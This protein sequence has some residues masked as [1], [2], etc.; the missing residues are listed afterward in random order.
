M[1]NFVN[2]EIVSAGPALH[3]MGYANVEDSTRKRVQSRVDTRPEDEILHP[4]LKARQ[5]ANA[6]DLYRN[7]PAAV[8]AVGL[9]V[10]A[11]CN[12]RFHSRTGIKS[13]DDR[14][15]YLWNWFQRPASCHVAQ[16]MSLSSIIRMVETRAIVDGDIHLL[17]VSTGNGDGRVQPIES[18]RIKSIG[19]ANLSGAQMGRYVQ[20]IEIDEGGKPLNY[21]VCK[22]QGGSLAFEK[23]VPAD[24]MLSHGY[25]PRFDCVRGVT[26][27]AASLDSF[28]DTKEGSEAALLK[29][30]LSQLLGV[31]FYTAAENA[32]ER[33]VDDNGSP[34]CSKYKVKLDE[35]RPFGIQMDP[36]GDRMEMV[37]SKTPSTEFQSFFQESLGLAF[38]TL[39]I[40]AG[41]YW[42][43]PNY[44]VS[45]LQR[46]FWFEFIQ[47][48]RDE[49]RT[50]LYALAAWRIGLWCLDSYLMLP[51][52][53]TV[54]DVMSCIEF[55]GKP[56]PSINVLDDVRAQV[57]MVKAGLQDGPRAIKELSG[58]DATEVNADA[59]AWYK[60]REARHLPPI[61]TSPSGQTTE[62]PVA[63]QN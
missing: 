45:K 32:V 55:V 25:Y 47:T 5:I 17:K 61:V 40:P 22:R 33:P 26:P 10:H 54:G 59:E 3:Q 18:D 56:L 52:G 43:G 35:G 42:N 53:W 4:A 58:N 34:I 51:R 30:K 11:V 20:G 9:T 2:S 57:E 12:L 7:Y 19:S 16:R 31:V 41:F 13:L 49:L 44:A 24:Q 1:P 37:E 48:R 63:V 46:D 60:D 38:K 39:H 27:L 62:P 36:Y 23:I 15:T 6:R 29:M 8:W 21:C 50:L 14:L 28:T